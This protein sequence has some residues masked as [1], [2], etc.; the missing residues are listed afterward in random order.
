TGRH[1]DLVIFPLSF[2][3]FLRFRNVDLSKRFEIVNKEIEIKRL[4][5]EYIE[6]G[7]FPEVVLGGEKKQI[8]LNYFSRA[9]FLFSKLIRKS[10]KE[11]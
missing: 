9:F 10:F 7:S 2:K 6:F 1:L 11:E 3:E 4:L 8:L 5:R